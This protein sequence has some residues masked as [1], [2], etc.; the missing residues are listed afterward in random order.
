VY[1][2]DEVVVVPVF[3]HVFGKDLAPFDDRIGMAELAM[4]W[5]DGVTVSPV[6]RELG[7]ESRTLNTIEELLRRR[8]ERSLRLVIGADVLADLPKWHRFDRICELAPP[9]VLGRA[10]VEHPDAPLPV[11]PRVSSTEIRALVRAGELER[12]R[13]LLPRAVLDHI[14]ERKLYSGNAS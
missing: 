13:P 2:V 8:P 12:V 11:L 5:I 10:G 14:T 1:A 6:E 3:Q 9:I 4:A 7:G